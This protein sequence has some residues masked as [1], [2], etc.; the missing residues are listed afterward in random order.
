MPEAAAA[1]A[2]GVATEVARLPFIG[3]GVPAGLDGAVVVVVVVVVGV[4]VAVAFLAANIALFRSWRL[5]R[6]LICK[7]TLCSV[8]KQITK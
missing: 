7:A 5:H 6:L 2:A 8:T 3:V 4:A 1:G